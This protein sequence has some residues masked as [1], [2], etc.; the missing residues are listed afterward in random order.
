M[1]QPMAKKSITKEKVDT[2]KKNEK[3]HAKNNTKKQTK[4]R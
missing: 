4:K 3:K 1:N 2:A